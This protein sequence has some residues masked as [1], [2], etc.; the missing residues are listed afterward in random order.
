MSTPRTEIADLLRREDGFLLASHAT[1]DG[2]ALGSLVAMGH[3][4]AAL[5][6]RFALYNQSGVPEGYDWL[7]LPGPVLTR[8]PEDDFAWT[9]VLDC[10]AAHRVGEDLE[11]RLR[12]E[13]TI[14]IDHHLGNPGFGAVNWVDTSMSAVGEMVAL[15]AHDLGVPLSGP[16]GEAVYLAVVTDTGSFTFGNT[17]PRVLSLA[18]EILSLG[19]DVADFNHKLLNNWSPGRLALWSRVLDRAHYTHDGKVGLVRISRSDLDATGTTALDTDNLVNM[20][21]RV[22]GVQVAVSLREDEPRRIKFSLR[23]SGDVNVQA[24]AATLGG[25]GHKNA[26]GG[27]V[28]ADLDTAEAVVE[29]AVAKGLGLS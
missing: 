2:D 14:N 16:L 3:L 18:A 7:P 1:P 28:E 11:P 4:L 29:A 23:S 8:V 24:M 22:R 27:T 17:Q 25:G 9:V 6:K 13:R 19:L 26:S 10:G 5:G 21:R 15:L 12:P 20:V